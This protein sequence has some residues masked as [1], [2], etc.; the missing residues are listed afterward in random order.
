MRFLEVDDLA[1]VRHV[2]GKTLA[3]EGFREC[4]L[5]VPASFSGQDQPLHGCRG[6]DRGGSDWSAKQILRLVASYP[7]RVQTAGGDAGR[8]VPRCVIV[9]SAG[10]KDHAHA[11]RE[12][13]TRTL[14]LSVAS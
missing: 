3:E 12:H 1:V 10:T 14:R 2:D 5:A 8:C 11:A 4:F 6:S 7:L 9:W 13:A